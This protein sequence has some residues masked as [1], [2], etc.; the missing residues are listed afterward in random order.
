MRPP[1]HQFQCLLVG[2]WDA[3][4]RYR[5]DWV[6]KI[7]GKWLDFVHFSVISVPFLEKLFAIVDILVSVIKNRLLAL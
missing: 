7:V 6:W 5:V 3:A 2:D 4:Y 1:L